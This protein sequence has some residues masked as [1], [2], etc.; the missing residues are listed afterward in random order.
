MWKIS[1]ALLAI[2]LLATPGCHSPVEPETG[3]A[4]AYTNLDVQ[5]LCFLDGMFPQAR[6]FRT[7][8]EWEVFWVAYCDASN[9]DGPVPPPVVDFE[10]LMM[11]GLFYEPVSSGCT[12]I[13][14]NG[15]E[16]IT[17]YSDRL[18]VQVGPVPDLGNCQAPQYPMT[19]VVVERIDLPVQFFGH[20]PG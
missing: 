7:S 6:V 3:T 10:N 13:V 18:E 4:V 9:D 15:V 12:C 11:V 16:S 2:C 8:S 17:R 20:V 14:E 19:I 1:L 5:G